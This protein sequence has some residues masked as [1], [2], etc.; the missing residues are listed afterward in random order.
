M[1]NFFEIPANLYY[2]IDH[3]LITKVRSTSLY[4]NDKFIFEID[5]QVIR[6]SNS[7]EPEFF[8]VVFNSK[9]LENSFYFYS[10]TFDNASFAVPEMFKIVKQN[11]EV[12]KTK[13]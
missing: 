4:Y 3:A 2:Q 10:D 11:L 13:R 9:N 5:F 1:K 7:N 12:E 8:I 6:R